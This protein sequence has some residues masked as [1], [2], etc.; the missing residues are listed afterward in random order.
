MNRKNI[1]VLKTLFVKFKIKYNYEVEEYAT[2][3]DTNEDKDLI[4]CVLNSIIRRFES[5]LGHGKFEVE[6][7][8]ISKL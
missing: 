5:R 4:E 7:V 1:P 2:S 8:N 3:I 6:I